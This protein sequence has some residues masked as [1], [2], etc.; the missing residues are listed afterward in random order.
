MKGYGLANVELSVPA[1]EESV[2]EIASV[3]KTFTATATIMLV[4]QNKISLDDSIADYLDDPPATWQPVTLRHILCH[5]SGIPSYTSVAD[6]WKTTRIDISRTEIIALVS[7]LPLMFS[8]G[9]YWSYDNTGY[10]LLGFMLE[11]VSGKPY[12]VLLREL[13]FEPLGMNATVM[14][15]PAVTI[16]NRVAG[17]YLE[18]N[19][20]YNKEYYSP[21]GTYSA[22]GWLSSVAD[23]LQ[24]EAALCGEQLLKQ[25]ILRQMWTPHESAKG[26]E[27]EK[28]SFTN[29]LGWHIPSYPNRKIVGHNGS[30]KGFAANMT[31]FI[32]DKV[33]VI[34]LCNLENIQRP[35]AIAKGIVE[36]FIPDLAQE[37]LKPPL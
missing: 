31:R 10:Y 7:E 24:W 17:Y 28:Y 6:Y 30:I 21:S 19:T 35:D 12:E 33:T 4:E 26:R 8:P 36:H 9:E 34:L 15:E 5:Q 20:L 11:K 25:S 1:T 29:G 3:G 22:G 37:T 27:R 23:M 18:N 2:Y 14:N 13:I 16:K 32:D